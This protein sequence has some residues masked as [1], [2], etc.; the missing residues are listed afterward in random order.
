MSPAVTPARTTVH[1]LRHGEVENPGKILYGRLPGFHLSELGRSMA[2]SAAEYLSGRDVR[3]LVSSPLERAQET[4]APLSQRTGL[5]VEL[6]ERTIEA[7]NDFEGLTVG[8]DPKQLASPRF[9][10]KLINPLRPSWGEPYA[11]L[12][13]R[14]AAAVRAARDAVPGHEAVIVSHQLPIWVLRLAAEQRRLWHDPRRRQ[15]NLASVTS[16]VFVGQELVAIEYAEPAAV[17]LAQASSV[18][19]A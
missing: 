19:G 4:A 18:P 13:S 8:A 3:L 2:D 11:Q 10:P 1:L 16:L 5:P 9:W 12:V 6:D 17:L 14:M 15:C 7:A